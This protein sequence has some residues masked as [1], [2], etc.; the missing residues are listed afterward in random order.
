[1]QVGNTIRHQQ[2]LRSLYVTGTKLTRLVGVRARDR[3]AI[4][5]LRQSV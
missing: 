3:Y 5:M 2:I 1:V 4:V